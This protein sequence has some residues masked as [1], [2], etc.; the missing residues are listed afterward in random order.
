[1]TIERPTKAVCDPPDF[2]H[3][4]DCTSERGKGH[5]LPMEGAVIGQKIHLTPQPAK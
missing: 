3:A 4:S 2:H 1:M 5:K